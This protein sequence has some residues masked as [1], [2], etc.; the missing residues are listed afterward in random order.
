MQT[1]IYHPL[2]LR[3]KGKCKHFHLRLGAKY[4]YE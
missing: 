2:C 1:H 3:L 4:E